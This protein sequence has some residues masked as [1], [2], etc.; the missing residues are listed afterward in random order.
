[1][2][3]RPGRCEP[4]I[5]FRIIHLAQDCHGCAPVADYRK[6]RIVIGAKGAFENSNIDALARRVATARAVSAVTSVR[7]MHNMCKEP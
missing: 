6:Q 2:R 5:Y 4:E 3:T 1:M 7:S